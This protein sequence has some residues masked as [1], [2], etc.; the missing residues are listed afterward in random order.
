LSEEVRLPLP[1]TQDR[2]HELLLKAFDA[3]T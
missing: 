2:F 1:T 3:A